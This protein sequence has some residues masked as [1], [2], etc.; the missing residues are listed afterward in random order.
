MDGS[1]G[2]LRSAGLLL[3]GLLAIGTGEAVAAAT[4]TAPGPSADATRPTMTRRTTMDLE[5]TYEL[6]TMLR[7]DAARLDVTETIAI[8]NRSAESIDALHL[9][10]LARA[11]GELEVRSVAVDGAPVDVR[12]PKRGTM[13]VPLATS[14]EPGGRLNVKVRFRAHASRD[15]RDSLHARL[16]KAEGMLRVSDWFP[17]LSDGHGLRD[18]G[19]SQYSVAARS[20]TLDLTTDRALDVAAPGT[21]VVDDGRHRVYRLE[22]ARNYGFTAAPNLRVASA[23]TKDGVRIRAFLPRGIRA[24]ATLREARRA[25]EAYDAFGPYPW[26]ELVVAPTPGRWIATES[27][28]LV[29]LGADRFADAQVIHHEV[30]HQWFYALLGN[31]QLRAPWLDEALAEFSSRWFFGGWDRRYCSRKRVDVPVYEFPDSFDRWGCGGYVQTVYAK[32]AAMVDGVRRRMGTTRFMRSMRALVAEHR[33]GIVTTTDV[34]DAWLRF[35]PRPGQLMAYLGRHLSRK[36]LAAAVRADR[37]AA[38]R[39]AEPTV[40]A[41]GPFG[42]STRSVVS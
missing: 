32:G 12:Y 14:V 27:P 8:V 13:L 18:P 37:R 1:I 3:L 6:R 41:N 17:I 29:F 15:V 2:R 30:A 36:A 10:V 21:L 40:A 5:A 39:R 16:S 42:T 33:F 11:H 22:N 31:D 34:V 24:R 26:P 28:A 19:D 25:L 23:T 9:S 4:R 20:I 38:G 7:Y 35:S